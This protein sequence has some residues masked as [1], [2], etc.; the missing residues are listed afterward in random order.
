MTRLAPLEGLTVLVTGTLP[1]LDRPRAHQVITALG[2]APVASVS[3]GTGLV[4]L[5]DG[6]GLSKMEKIRTHNLR[7]VDGE[8]FEQLIEGRGAWTSPPGIPC[9][10]WEATR[11]DV[12]DTDPVEPVDATPMAQRHLLAKAS[13]G[14]P[15]PNGRSVTEHR[16]LCLKCGTVR[17]SGTRDAVLGPCPNDPGP[18]GTWSEPA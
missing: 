14:V 17:R 7:V 18:A 1:T 11:P 10:D 2:G 15:G 9:R 4:V 5:G 13:V 16:V 12:A 8:E 6:A 3:R